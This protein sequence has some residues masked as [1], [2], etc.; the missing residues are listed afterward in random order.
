M[1]CG[2]QLDAK[3]S[4]AV[5]ASV[6]HAA[7]WRRLA[8]F[9]RSFASRRRIALRAAG[10]SIHAS[11]SIEIIENE[12]SRLPWANWT[13]PQPYTRDRSAVVAPDAAREPTATTSK[14]WG[15]TWNKHA[16][17]WKAQYCDANGKQRCL[18]YFDT[19][20][21]A[22]RA[23]NAA[24]RRAGL[25]GKRRMNAVVDGQLVP[26]KKRKARGHGPPRKS[27]ARRRR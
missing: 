26:P 18:G 13:Q 16:R 20:E 6:L 22:A 25:A 21:Q 9:S 3:N 12:L 27:R 23:Y 10:S 11:S 1:W 24:I 5:N 4:S 8:L 14:F 15:V 2:Q 17:R 7:S 19:Q